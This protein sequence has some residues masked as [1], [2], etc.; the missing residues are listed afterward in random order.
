MSVILFGSILLRISASICSLVVLRRTGDRRILFFTAMLVLM[1]T[2][3]VLTFS[4]ISPSWFGLN[5]GISEPLHELPG[6]VVSLMALLLIVNLGG[7]LNP[8]KRETENP[9]AAANVPVFSWLA[10]GLAAITGIIVV[11]AFAYQNSRDAIR[12]TVSRQNLTLARTVCRAA[13]DDQAPIRPEHFSST[14]DRLNGIWSKTESPFDQ[15][16]LCV[17]DPSGR[18]VLHTFSPEFVGEN[19]SDVVVSDTTGKTIGQLLAAK[20][21]SV[22]QNDN[23][24][25]VRQLVGYHYEPSLGS[26]VAIH[27]PANIV[28]SGFDHAVAPWVVSMLL[29]GCLVLPLALGLLYYSSRQSQTA[30]MANLTA[31]AESERRYRFF[32]EQTQEGFYRLDFIPPIPIDQS[33]DELIRQSY[34]RGAVVECNDIFAQTYGY[35]NASEMQDVRLAD[36]HGGDNVPENIDAMRE[37]IRCGYRHLDVETTE[38]SKSGELIFMSNNSVGIIEN[39]R[40]VSC[41]GT[42]RDVTERRKAEHDIR[43]SERRFRT[44]FE[45]AAVG[46]AQQDSVSGTLLKVNRRCCEIFDMPQEMLVGTTWMDRTLPEEAEHISQMMQRLLAGEVRE[47]DTE[48][49]VLRPDGSHVWI[50]LTISPMWQTGEDPTTHIAIIEDITARRAAEQALRLEEE[51]YRLLVTSSSACVWICDAQGMFRD[52]QPLWEAYTGQPWEQH[53]GRGWTRMLHP[54]DVAHVKA[55]WDRAIQSAEFYFVEARVFHQASGD[56]RYFEARATPLLNG[57]GSVREWIGAMIDVHKR[58]L[59][60]NRLREQHE[61]TTCLLATMLDGYVLIDST[62]CLIDVNA[63]YCE[64]IG[65]DRHELLGRNL[66]DLLAPGVELQVN[67]II[68]AGCL[69]FETTHQCRNGDVVDLDVSTTVLP[70]GNAQAPLIAGFSRD[71]T[72][73]KRVDAELRLRDHAFA[74]GSSGMI[75]VDATQDDLPIIYCNP[76][77]ER[78]TGYTQKEILGRNPRFL[79]HDDRDQPG[80]FALR[81]AIESRRAV[82]T[83]LRNYRKDGSMFWTEASISPVRDSDGR[84][85]HYLGFQTDVT[86]RR[87]A[88]LA[89]LESREKLRVQFAELELVY[90]TAP[91]GLCL[92]D[93]ELNCVRV[94]EQMAGITGI[95]V[96]QHT[97]RPFRTVLPDLADAVVP[98]CLKVIETGRPYLNFDIE[99]RH[100]TKSGT[101]FNYLLGFHPLKNDDSSMMGVSVVIQDLTE[102]LRAERELQIRYEAIATS[103]VPTCFGDDQFRFT[104]VNQALLDLLGLESEEQ[105]I[106]TLSTDFETSPKSAMEINAELIRDGS[107]I[108]ELTSLRPD[109]TPIE[110]FVCATMLKTES[111]DYDR[112]MTTMWDITARKQAERRLRLTQASVDSCGMPILWIRS[113]AAFFYAN[114]AAAACCRYSRDE[115]L[116]LRVSDIDPAYP[117]ERWPDYWKSLQQNRTLAFESTIKR[118]DGSLFPA[119]ISTTLL[120]FEGE[121]FVLA[122]MEDITQ[123][124]QSEEKRLRD[125]EALRQSE[126][127]LLELNASLERR[128][129][130]RTRE[131]QDA[132]DDLEA[133]AQSVAHD[134]RAPLRAMYGFAKALQEDYSDVLDAEG[135]EYTGYIESAARQMDDLIRDLLEYSQ[136][137]ASGMSIDPVRLDD[138]VQAA[139]RQLEPE[140]VDRHAVIRFEPPLPTTTGHFTTLVRV[141][142]NLIGN[143]IKF[144]APGTTPQVSVWCDQRDSRLRIWVKDNGI[145]I[146]PEMQERIFRVFERLHGIETYPGTGIGLAIVRRAVDSMNGTFG[147]ESQPGQGSQFWVELPHEA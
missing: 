40:L 128:V 48:K 33:E 71:I 22:A 29:T 121:E 88:E 83:T 19:V 64:L 147:V 41:W 30:A 32:V 42:Q 120:Q 67:R 10:V 140:I 3:Q 110:L 98:V 123:R 49:R 54:D 113:N 146:A 45:Q 119:Q 23:I 111:G 81:K 86:E 126:I 52:P 85:T 77:F 112:F 56:Y 91:V 138:V 46:V 101:T 38:C 20:K 57:D 58:R 70:A 145:G 117:A 90:R 28:D 12:Q 13:L 87:N 6:L 73:R 2:R 142:S 80:R 69:R 14:I 95:A 141:L 115:L 50:H 5:S 43:E 34:Q 143:A 133:Y 65:Y 24:R 107:W 25:G 97:G 51:R 118:K 26:L 27:V 53:Q 31:L 139:V 127:L 122:F 103:V 36:L 76:A 37:F 134:L 124:K 109:G 92:L 116:S 15:T 93:V 105:I 135:I 62:G 104:Y 108:G 132:N 72:N 78:L 39:D 11:S 102:K 8:R 99:R 137:G 55:A 129:T 16:Y 114:E 1:T 79:Q 44:I 61:N 131:L 35:G 63:A 18:L 7:F 106:G 17:I 144:T 4:A 75:I 136:V 100:P 66:Q 60:E 82:V 68:Q 84:L 130:E 94:N 125:E 47:F 9:N 74:S 59:A 89:L 21:D 96:E